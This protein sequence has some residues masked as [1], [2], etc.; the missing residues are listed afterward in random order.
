M[1]DMPHPCWDEEVENLFVNKGKKGKQ[2]NGPSC[3]K[4]NFEE[5]LKVTL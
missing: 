3:H 4:V 5:Q 1:F 2:D